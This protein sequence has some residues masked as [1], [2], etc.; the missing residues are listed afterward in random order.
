MGP[1]IACRLPRGEEAGNR[2]R[3]G[4]AEKKLFLGKQIHS[5]PIPNLQGFLIPGRPFVVP[6]D[7]DALCN[8]L[9]K[10]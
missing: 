3:R 10:S 9:M 4:S 6:D 7:I 5:D 8:S 1:E 2:D